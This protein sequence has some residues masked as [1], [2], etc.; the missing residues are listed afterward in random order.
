M[1]LLN[2]LLNLHSGVRW[3]VMLASVAALVWFALVWLA[4]LR[5]EKADRILMAAFNGLLDLQVTLGLVYLIASGMAGAGFPR[6]RLEHGFTMLVAALVAHLAV[7]WRKAEVK[8]R[9]RN[10]TLLIV[11]VLVLVFIGLSFLPRA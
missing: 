9:A 7:R 2:F 6:Y 8:I 3:L 5:N 1:D 4:G 11:G 10:N